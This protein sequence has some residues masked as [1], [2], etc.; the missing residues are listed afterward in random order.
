MSEERKERPFD[1]GPILP[2]FGAGL[3]LGERLGSMDTRLGLV[4]TDLKEVKRDVKA[5]D[6]R[7]DQVETRLDRLETKVDSIGKAV[8][9]LQDDM[10]DV[11]TGLR[12]LREVRRYDRAL[13]VGLW[14]TVAAGIILQFFK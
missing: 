9:T 3:D 12:I 4:E 6:A 5:L 13:M 1:L 11:K 10:S 8:R 2:M 7:L 14:I